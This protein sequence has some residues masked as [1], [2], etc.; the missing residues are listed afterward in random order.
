MSNRPR[1]LVT[2]ASSGIG[3]VFA[4]RLAKEGHDLIVVARRRER[5]EELGRRLHAEHGVE[6]EV[7]AADLTLREDRARVEQAIARDDRLALLINNAGAGRYG[8]FIELD[9]DVAEEILALET[10]A[11]VR[12][13]RA[14]LPGMVKRGNG[15]I[16]C[17]A[18]LLAFSGSLP[19][20][21]GMPNRVC[22]AGGKSLQ[23][24]FAQTLSHE[25]AGTG[26]KVMVCCPGI[27]ATEFHT[28]QGMDLSHLPRMTPEQ[29]VQAALAGLGAGETVC[30]PGLEDRAALDRLIE[31]Q[32]A[33]LGASQKTEIA[34]RYRGEAK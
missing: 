21:M 9:P 25:L 10:L 11:P 6:V 12:L 16:I 32:R 29:I 13:T 22:Y 14:A 7:L 17:V 33:L 19:P 2:G 34:S 30:I 1:A 5:L 31:T 3:A 27:V 23:V 15:G 8:K 26:V 24:T 20:G 18:S 28:V 4:E